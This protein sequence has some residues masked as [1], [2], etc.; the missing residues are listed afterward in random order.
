MT[1]SGEIVPFVYIDSIPLVGHNLNTRTENQS[2]WLNRRTTPLAHYL[3]QKT[4]L[5]WPTFILPFFLT[6]HLTHKNM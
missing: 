6:T 5:F 3:I 4:L 2:N 1:I